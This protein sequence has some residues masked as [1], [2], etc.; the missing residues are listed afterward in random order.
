[1]YD[2]DDYGL[3]SL[4]DIEKYLYKR[5]IDAKAYDSSHD[6]NIAENAVVVETSFDHDV[7]RNTLYSVWPIGTVMIVR[8]PEI[9]VCLCFG[10]PSKDCR[11][12]GK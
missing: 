4:S 1:M 7:V 6:A 5:G 11:I 12:H 9:G 2:Y 3:I 10:P 8:N